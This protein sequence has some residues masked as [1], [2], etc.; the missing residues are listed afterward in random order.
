MRVRVAG[1]AVG[2]TRVDLGVLRKIPSKQGDGRYE[3]KRSGAIRNKAKRNE[4]TLAGSDLI[5]LCLKVVNDENPRQLG[6]CSV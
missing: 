6:G 1:V 3:T 2:R 4:T 5:D